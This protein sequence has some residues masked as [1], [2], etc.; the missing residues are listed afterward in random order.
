M[1]RKP[2][3]PFP[4]QPPKN[5]RKKVNG[6]SIRALVTKPMKEHMTRVFSARGLTESDYVRLALYHQLRRDDALPDELLDDNTWKSLQD[7]G[8]V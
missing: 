2:K 7:L 1:A 8:L 5:P 4:G 6:A 3:H